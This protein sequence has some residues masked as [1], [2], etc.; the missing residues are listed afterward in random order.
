[1]P[2]KKQHKKPGYIAHQASDCQPSEHS[3]QL[4][5]QGFTRNV[6]VINSNLTCL[7]KLSFSN[8]S[9]SHNPQNINYNQ[10]TLFP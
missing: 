6:S 7:L 8:N 5:S 3:N 1:M 10:K 2:G 4:K 9:Q